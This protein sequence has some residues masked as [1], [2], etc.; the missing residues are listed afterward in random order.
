MS[1]LGAMMTSFGSRERVRW[2]AG[3]AGLAERQQD[4]ALRAELD[5]LMAD[6]F[7]RRRW[8]RRAR[9]PR[10]APA[11]DGCRCIGH[12]DVAVAIDVDAVRRRRSCPAPKLFT[13]CPSRRISARDRES[14]SRRWPDRHSCWRR[15]ARRPRS[16]CHPCR[17]P[18]RW[19]IPSSAR[20]AA[21]E[22]LD[23]L[24]RIRQIVGR[25]DVGLRERPPSGDRRHREDQRTRKL[26]SSDLSDS[27]SNF[28][29]RTSN[30]L[31]LTSYFFTYFLTAF[32]PT[33]AP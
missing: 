18:R 2:I 13:S 7:G 32:G 24:V 31:L 28:S 21:E 20:A 3:D 6:R 30:F 8:R 19:S 23:R 17:Y 1:P 26:H 11:S 22:I 16:S 27:T 10:R 12:P 25:R 33:S 14:T 4:F 15:S 9:A 29:L 5:D